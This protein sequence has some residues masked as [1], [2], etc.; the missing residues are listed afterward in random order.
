MSTTVPLCI[1]VHPASNFP[2]GGFRRIFL[3]MRM[4]IVVS[5]IPSR[6]TLGVGAP[7]CIELH[8]PR[9]VWSSSFFVWLRGCLFIDVSPVPLRCVSSIGVPSRI[10]LPRV[11][12]I[13]CVFC[14][15][16]PFCHEE[17]FGGGMRIVVPLMLYI[18]TWTG[19]ASRID[20]SSLPPPVCCSG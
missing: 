12:I 7:S 3:A 10:E 11:F 8:A 5:R 2:L 13:V 17:S 15:L 4:P 14:V 16:R 19:V 6:Y 1:T 20:V 18:P 9:P